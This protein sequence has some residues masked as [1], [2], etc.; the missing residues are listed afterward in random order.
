MGKKKRNK[1]R[2]KK[3]KRISR[4][5]LFFYLLYLIAE[6]LYS[7]ITETNLHAV[8]IRVISTFLLYIIF[9]LNEFR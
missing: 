4:A 7:Y 5:I 3:R 6:L 8:L 1:I 2:A 9:A